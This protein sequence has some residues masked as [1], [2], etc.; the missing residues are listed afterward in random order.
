MINIDESMMSTN[1]PI[2]KIKVLVFEI[3]ELMIEIN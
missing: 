3:N 1:E 2:I